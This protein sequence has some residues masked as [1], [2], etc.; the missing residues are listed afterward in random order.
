[1]Q[2]CIHHQTNRVTEFVMLT[3]VFVSNR[4]MRKLLFII[5]QTEAGRKTSRLAL[6]SFVS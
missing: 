3:A 5:D 1:M 4:L 2:A 6:L